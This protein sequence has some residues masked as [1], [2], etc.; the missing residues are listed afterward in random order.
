MSQDIPSKTPFYLSDQN[1]D[2]PV[3]FLFLDGDTLVLEFQDKYPTVKF[4]SS[5]SHL[6]EIVNDSSIRIELPDN[7]GKRIRLYFPSDGKGRFVVYGIRE[8]T[9]IDGSEPRAK[10]KQAFLARFDSFGA[11]LV[12]LWQLALPFLIYGSTFLLH[13]FVPETTPEVDYFNAEWQRLAL[14]PVVAVHYAFLLIPSVA[15]LFYNRLWGLRIMFQAN[16]ML[17]LIVA[18]C[19]FL[20]DSWQFLFTP[21]SPLIL[22]HYWLIFAPYMVLLLA[23][24]FYYVA[25]MRRL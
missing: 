13:T 20:P 21:E 25:I 12:A 11:K 3:G 24:A 4:K 19:A 14:T 23:P 5:Q 1:Q 8:W 18:V 7:P 22:P 9:G 2:A 15:I 16:L 17:V 6:V 10:R